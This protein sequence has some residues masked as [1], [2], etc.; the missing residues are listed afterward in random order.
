M[1]ALERTKLYHKAPESQTIYDNVNPPI[2]VLFLLSA[3]YN[4]RLI[5]F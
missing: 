3:S 1:I 5:L 4:K 2:D